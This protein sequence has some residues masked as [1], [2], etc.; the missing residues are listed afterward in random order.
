[1]CIACGSCMRLCPSQCITVQGEKKEGDKRKYPT[2][3][4][5]DFTRCSLCGTCSEACPVGAIDYSAVYGLAGYT[6]EEFVY[7][8]LADM[9]GPATAGSQAASGE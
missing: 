5:V 9:P 1:K 4:Q 8:L 6:R 7:D 3:F 2:V